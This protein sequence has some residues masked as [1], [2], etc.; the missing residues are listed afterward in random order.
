[1][2]RPFLCR[3]MSQIFLLCFSRSR[4]LPA[5]PYDMVRH[6]ADEID[7]AL[8]KLSRENPRDCFYQKGDPGHVIQWTSTCEAEQRENPTAE[9]M[10]ARWPVHT[11]T[12]W[13]PLLRASMVSEFH[14]LPRWVYTYQ[15]RLYYAGEP[16]GRKPS[17]V[18]E[19]LKETRSL[20]SKST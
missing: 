16:F 15:Q 12:Q 13:T 9:I 5:R 1:M 11:E 10:P 2:H 4:L 8:V 20:F 3:A 19:A 6:M 18:K 14:Q 7:R 17:A